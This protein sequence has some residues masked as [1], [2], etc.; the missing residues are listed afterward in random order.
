MDFRSDCEKHVK[1]LLHPM[2]SVFHPFF[3]GE[4]L[5]P[6]AQVDNLRVWVRQWHNEHIDKKFEFLMRFRQ[7]PDV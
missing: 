5:K 3:S 4:Q 2:Q 7:G 1:V 6:A